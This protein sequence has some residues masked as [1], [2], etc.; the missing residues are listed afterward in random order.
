MKDLPIEEV[1]DLIKLTPDQ[2]KAWKAFEKAV[3]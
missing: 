1:Q 2:E 3:K